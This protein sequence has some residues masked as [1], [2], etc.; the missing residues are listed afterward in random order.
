MDQETVYG[1]LAGKKYKELR[2]FLFRGKEK[3]KNDPMLY[4]AAKTVELEF[5]RLSMNEMDDEEF[6]YTL[7]IFH[8]F[9]PKFYEIQSD[10]FKKITL[11][12]AFYHKNNLHTAIRF[13]KLYPE[14]EISIEIIKLHSETETQ[15]IEH[16]NEEY[17]KITHNPIPINICLLY[18]SPSPRD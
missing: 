10:N 2:E 6:R 7:E 15:I 17:I 5:A 16:D 13:A 4:A 11:N 1:W 18:T 8:T 12:L 14:E 9:H 3:I